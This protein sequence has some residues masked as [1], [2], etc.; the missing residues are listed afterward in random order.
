LKQPVLN[1][2]RDDVTRK[3][4]VILNT[5]IVFSFAAVFVRLADIMVLKNSFYSE[6]AKSQQIKTE[7]IQA[8]RG[9]IY[10]RR[11]REVAVNLELESLYCDPA[12]AG[13]TPAHIKR[14]SSVLHTEP[15]ELKAKLSQEKRFVWI[16]RKLSR[17]SAE[18]IR[19]LNL[20]GFGFMPEAKRYYRR[21]C[22]L[23]TLS[24][25]SARKTSR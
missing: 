3:R 20:K 18:Q 24:A 5:I 14:L 7:D 16:D 8:R 15:K 17:E 4:A 2:G 6:K 12:E 9:N 10:D 22:W 25:P 23:H 13:V 21:A 19:K 1:Q 11:G